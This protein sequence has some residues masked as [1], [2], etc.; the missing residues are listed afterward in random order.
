MTIRNNTATLLIG[1]VFGCVALTMFPACAGGGEGDCDVDTAVYTAQS[2]TLSQL[3]GRVYGFQFRTELDNYIRLTG[4]SAYDTRQFV[5][6][7]EATLDRRH[8]MAYVSGVM[9]GLNLN[10]DVEAL[11]KAGFNID[12]RAVVEAIEKSLANANDTTRPD[13]LNLN[14]LADRYT[15]LAARA[16]ENADQKDRRAMTDSLQTAYKTFISAMIAENM[17]DF[18]RNEGREINTAQFL[19]GIERVFSETHAQEF[20]SGVYQAVNMSQQFVAV[21]KKGVNIRPETVMKNIRDV[22]DSKTVDTA[23]YHKA[24]ERLGEM[25]RR[26][27][28]EAYKAEDE[29]LAASDKAIQIIKTGEALVNALKKSD[30]EIKTSD[31]GLSYRIYNKGEG[32]PIAAADTVTLH[33]T[34]SHLDNKVFDTRK[35]ARVA[36]SGLLPGLREGVSLLRKGGKA[37]LWVPGAL[38]YGGHGAPSAGVGPMETIVF[39]IEVLDVTPAR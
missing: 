24:A 35:E 4:D 14:D 7:L 32:A 37:T 29:Q 17:R 9:L 19:K 34:A 3:Y 28:E 1:V 10:V 31:S 39:D 23:Y 21:E 20:Y 33:Y 18:R 30:P 26:I 25:L 16:Q 2:D 22:F 13:N 38:G 15:R 11:D 36:M 12:R 6:G 5:D 8:S 27:D